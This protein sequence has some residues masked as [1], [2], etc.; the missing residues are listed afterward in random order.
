MS[1]DEMSKHSKEE[2]GGHQSTKRYENSAPIPSDTGDSLK[3]A[4]A[5]QASR[6]DASSSLNA[7][8]GPSPPLRRKSTEKESSSSDEDEC[9]KQGGRSFK[10]R[11]SGDDVAG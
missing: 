6:H 11:K 5:D 2:V 8:V 4:A 1:P 7:K 3:D 10:K 9:E